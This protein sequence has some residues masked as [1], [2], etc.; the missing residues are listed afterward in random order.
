[1]QSA[2]ASSATC[3]AIL[4]ALKLTIASLFAM[5]S[6]G[7]GVGLCDDARRRYVNRKPVDLD[8]HCVDFSLLL[9]RRQHTRVEC[10]AVLE[11]AAA[12]AFRGN[13]GADG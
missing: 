2:I 3:S 11:V 13:R 12:R 10:S 7:V 5:I 8:E 9:G 6:L 1:M 4:A